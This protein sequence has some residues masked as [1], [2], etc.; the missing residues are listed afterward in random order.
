M[1]NI[2]MRVNSNATKQMEALIAKVDTF[3][4]RIA[5]IQ[6]SSLARSRS[7]IARKLQRMNAGAK[8]LE[9][10]IQQSGVLGHKL[11]IGPPSGNRNKEY[12]AA[13]NFIKGRPGGQI[14]R[15][16]NGG[17]MKLRDESVRKGYPEYLREIK[18]AAL[19]SHKAQIVLEMRE[20]VLKNIEYS[21]KRFGFGPRGGSAGLEDLP[22]PRSR[23][24][25]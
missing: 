1:S 8:Y 25:R 23:V 14:V 21:A 19:P 10:D 18:M 16:K 22:M 5:S 24:G 13:Y 17:Y 11:T 15:G 7:E 9:Y 20:I 12:Y 6:Q 4:N 2:K 3:P